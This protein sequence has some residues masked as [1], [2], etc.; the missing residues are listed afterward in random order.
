MRKEIDR[1]RNTLLHNLPIMPTRQICIFRLNASCIIFIQIVNKIS[2]EITTC[3]F[4][5]I[6][7]NTRIM[8]L[9]HRI[10]YGLQK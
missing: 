10:I 2:V 4:T 5:S 3:P 9:K 8:M 6:Y 7:D 1:L